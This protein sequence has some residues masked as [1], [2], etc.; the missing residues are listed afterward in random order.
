MPNSEKSVE[1]DVGQRS[2]NN[3]TAQRIGKYSR[4][5]FQR[6]TGKQHKNDNYSRGK[7]HIQNNG[8]QRI[9]PHKH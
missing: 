8:K 1:N 7:T 6:Q 4:R 5:F 2:R 9:A 3:T